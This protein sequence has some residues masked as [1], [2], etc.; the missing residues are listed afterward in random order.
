MPKKI[1][2]DFRGG[3]ANNDRL[4]QD[5]QFDIGRDIDIHRDLG[6]LKPGYLG[7][8]L[9]SVSQL[10]SLVVDFAVKPAHTAPS[11]AKVYAIETTK[12]HQIDPSTDGIS[13][14]SPYP[15]ALPGGKDGKGVFF[16]DSTAFRNEVYFILEDNIGR[17]NADLPDPDW[18]S[19]V[20]AGGATLSADSD[21]PYVVW[22]NYFWVGNGNKLGKYDGETGANGTWTAAALLLPSNYRIS[23]LFESQNFIGIC[24]WVAYE[25][26]GILQLSRYR[27]KSFVLLWDGVSPTYNYLIPI[28]DNKITAAENVNGVVHLWTEKRDLAGSLYILQNDGGRRVKRLQMNLAGTVINM[29]SP[30]LHAI[31]GYDGKLLFGAGDYDLIMAYGR[32][33]EES[34]V[35]F[36]QPFSNTAVSGGIVGAIKVVDTDKIYASF[37]VSSTY[38]IKK[39][40]SGNSASASWKPLYADFGQKVRINYIKAYFKPLATSDAITLGLELNYGKD[41]VTLGRGSSNISNSIEGSVTEKRFDI[42]RVCHSFRPTINWVA[43]GVAVSKVVVDYDYVDDI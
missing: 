38:T 25:S 35:A 14:T 30:K 33:D 28:S 20:P 18:L 7:T 31:D 9:N 3:F 27:T 34:P 24:V 21:H 36:F 2:S 19:T 15:Y 12:L 42:K 5:N 43:G 41:T 11:T 6:Y 29:A 10:S 8:V 1:Y 32:P 23:A 40:T 13:S 37:Q 4:G 39:F 26:S 17:L 22:Q 16:F